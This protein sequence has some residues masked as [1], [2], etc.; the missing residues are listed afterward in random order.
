[1]SSTLSSLSNKNGIVSVEL[2][3]TEVVVVVG[4]HNV[5]K[6]M[7]KY[8]CDSGKL[9]KPVLRHLRLQTHAEI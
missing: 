4:L 7:I 8:E 2:I 9:L 6:C 3:G 5:Q 1:M